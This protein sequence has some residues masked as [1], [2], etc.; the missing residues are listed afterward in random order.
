MSLSNCSPS[1]S[2]LPILILGWDGMHPNGKEAI[3]GVYT[4]MVF[5]KGQDIVNVNLSLSLL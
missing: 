4:W 1:P 5:A 2:L 3:Q